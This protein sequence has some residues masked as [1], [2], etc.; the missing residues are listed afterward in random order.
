MVIG[1][2]CV[3][4]IATKII[5]TAYEIYLIFTFCCIKS[6]II[7]IDKLVENGFK[8]QEAIGMSDVYKR[9][10]TVLLYH[11]DRKEILI[12]TNVNPNQKLYKGSYNYN[13]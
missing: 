9:G 1:L 4:S 10:Y 7:T 6:E 8:R 11:R 2:V 12:K 13:L 5:I 3:K